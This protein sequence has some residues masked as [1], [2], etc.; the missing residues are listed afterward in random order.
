MRMPHRRHSRTAA[1][2]KITLT[3]LIDTVLTLL[4]I[5]MVTTPMMH[6]AIKVNL[7]RGRVKEDVGA[8]QDLTVY[9]D[10]HQHL[11]IN[12][13]ETT[14]NEII[15]A[16]RRMVGTNQDKLVYVHAD[17]VVSFGFV[18]ELVDQMKSIGGIAHV[19]LATQRA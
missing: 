3:P 16:L 4:I 12:G 7:P 17:Q 10:K 2:P 6:N 8:N 19:A 18:T 15:P 9:I 14:A 5:F 1:A 11:Y 13:T